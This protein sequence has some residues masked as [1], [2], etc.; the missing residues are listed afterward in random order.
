MGDFFNFYLVWGQAWAARGMI[1]YPTKRIREY[2]HDLL[3]KQRGYSEDIWLTNAAR[4]GNRDGIWPFSSI[5]GLWLCNISQLNLLLCSRCQLYICVLFEQCWDP[6]TWSEVALLTSCCNCQTFYEVA[7]SPWSN[8]KYIGLTVE[9][10]YFLHILMLP[11]NKHKINP[12]RLLDCMQVFCSPKSMLRFYANP[13]P[14]IGVFRLAYLR[15]IGI[16]LN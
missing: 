10:W 5:A 7:S 8:Y 6:V 13:S 2:E 3:C 15:D 4:V 12:S 11:W 9:H 16:W 1:F 14:P